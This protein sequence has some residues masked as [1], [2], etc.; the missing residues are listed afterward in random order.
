[1]DH[2]SIIIENE[3][4]YE[5]ILYIQVTLVTKLCLWNKK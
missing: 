1:M 2:E 3:N 5:I 4:N